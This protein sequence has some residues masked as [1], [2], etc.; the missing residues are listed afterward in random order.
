MDDGGHRSEM[1][2]PQGHCISFMFRACDAARHVNKDGSLVSPHHPGD[3]KKKQFAKVNKQLEKDT[4]LV[5]QCREQS[6]RT[7][8]DFSEMILH[9]STQ[10]APLNQWAVLDDGQEL[11]NVEANSKRRVRKWL[12]S[13]KV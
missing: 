9:L 11:N 5:C 2:H 6:E 13:K 7:I 10:A 8:D 1:V 12:T 4:Q 3:E